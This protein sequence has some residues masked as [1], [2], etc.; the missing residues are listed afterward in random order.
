[1]GLINKTT[2]EKLL[3]L[4]GELKNQNEII[5]R[6]KIRCDEAVKMANARR[7]DLKVAIQRANEQ[8]D[9]LTL[10]RRNK[11]ELMLKIADMEIQL[12]NEKHENDVL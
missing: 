1:M 8:N 7:N 9:I 2:E 6:T 10:E 5:E 3:K 4:E 12:L 11:A